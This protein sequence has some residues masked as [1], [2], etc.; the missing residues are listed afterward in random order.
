MTSVP[1]LTV[2]HLRSRWLSQTETW[3]YEQV[4]YLPPDVQSHVVC[5]YTENLDQFSLPNIHSLSDDTS[6]VGLAG[7]LGRRLNLR[8]KERSL[9]G[10]LKRTGASIAHSHFGNDAWQNLPIVG[11]AGIKHVTTFY[12]MDASRLPTVEP[13]W[14][15]RYHELFAKVD[16]VLCEG[17]HMARTIQD[18]GCPAEKVRVHHLGV[19]V[20]QI[21]YRPR[22]W[23]LGEPLKILIAGS[24]REKKGIPYAI[25]AAGE[26]NKRVPV[27][28]TIIG[29]ASAEPRCQEEKQA[30]LEKLKSTGLDAKTRMVG[31]QPHTIFF[32]EACN[33]HIFL[34]PSVH[35]S[36]GD[37]EGGAPVSII[38]VMATGMPVVG[39]THC[40]IPNVIAEGTGL[41]AP[42]R[43]VPAL[44]TH[45]EWLVTHPENWE[46]IAS[47][48]RH[49]VESEFDCATQGRRLAQIY[50]DVVVS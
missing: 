43:D 27:E 42:E 37:T 35:A 19:K 22:R 6:V 2:A 34:S 14:R 12:G 23:K 45:L 5:S 24:F 44:V 47:A 40:D 20:D 28:L 39:T 1:T 8:S 33:N 3:I 18:L 17:P 50:R 21:E 4:R 26:L 11:A 32:E 31:F 36:D 7:K 38:E 10:I 29:D 13:V 9:A 15:E 25:A 30:I 16:R 49:R 41:L 46:S 48:A